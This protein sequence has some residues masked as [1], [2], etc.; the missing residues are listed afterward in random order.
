[1]KLPKL[2][3]ANARA[4][5]MLLSFLLVVV[6]LAIMVWVPDLRENET[7]RM[8]AQ[9]IVMQGFF[10]LIV[11]FYFTDSEEKNHRVQDEEFRG[12]PD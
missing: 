11:A 2:T 1:M 9:A 12:K 3:P 4:T 5:L 10:G 8:L 7:F 6:V